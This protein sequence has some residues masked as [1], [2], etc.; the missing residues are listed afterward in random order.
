MSTSVLSK[1]KPLAPVVPAVV[2]GL[3]AAKMAGP[4]F[5]RLSA[6]IPTS[7]PVLPPLAPSHRIFGSV[8]SGVNRSKEL[9]QS[10]NRAGLSFSW[11]LGEAYTRPI[12]AEESRAL[13]RFAYAIPG[14]ITLAAILTGLW[15]PMDAVKSRLQCRGH[16]AWTC[17]AGEAKIAL[18]SPYAGATASFI[19]RI[20][21]Y[22]TMYLAKNGTLAYFSKGDPDYSFSALEK[23]AAA[24][25][26]AIPTSAIITVFDA[27]KLGAMATGEKIG[28]MPFIRQHGLFKFMVPAVVGATFLREEAFMCAYSFA[29][30]TPLPVQLGLGF[31]AGIGSNPF[32]QLKSHLGHLAN[33]AVKAGKS[34]SSVDYVAE[35]KAFF[36]AQGLTRLL[37][38]PAAI[39][40]GLF[41]AG[42]I[43]I[44]TIGEDALVRP[45][46]LA[47]HRTDFSDPKEDGGDGFNH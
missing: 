15:N 30:G 21:T 23:L 45:F 11:H 16:L 8:H 17:A 46:K 44:L 19:G 34:V 4:G 35:A 14:S 25:V 28:L 22:V 12:T 1:F 29:T 2:G 6:G 33:E 43:A 39:S 40:R 32:D 38:G 42:T 9:L 31:V 24:T 18:R 3:V 37:V 41:V 5:S 47:V 20:P 27:P 36:K 7:Q 10:A 13:A 26:A